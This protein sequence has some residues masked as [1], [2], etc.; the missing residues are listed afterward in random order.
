MAIDVEAFLQSLP[1][2][3]PLP[4]DRELFSFTIPISAI[5]VTSKDVPRMRSVLK[6]RALLLDLPKIKP[7]VKDETKGSLS[8]LLNDIYQKDAIPLDDVAIHEYNLSIGYSYWT[9]SQIFDAILPPELERITSFET[10]GHI[11]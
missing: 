10:I 4:L 1:R 9:V 3:I 7:I 5:S 11:G 2:P 6:E 8:I